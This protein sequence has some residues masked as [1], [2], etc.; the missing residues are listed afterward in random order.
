MAQPLD[1]GPAQD[2][3]R[4]AGVHLARPVVPGHVRGADRAGRRGDHVVEDD[5]H[6]A[7]QRR[8]D[9]VGLSHLRVADAPLVL[10]RANRTIRFSFY[11]VGHGS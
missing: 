4:R 5:R 9:Q 10:K 8:P 3:V 1:G 7:L 6:L 11:I 2:A